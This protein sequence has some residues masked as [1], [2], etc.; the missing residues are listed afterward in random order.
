MRRFA[1]PPLPTLLLLALAAAALAQ[2]GGAAAQ[3]KAADGAKPAAGAGASAEASAAGIARQTLSWSL[4]DAIS[5]GIENNLEVAIVRYD[6]IAADYDY[7]AAL[8]AHAPVLGGAFTYEN[9]RLPVSSSFQAP[10]ERE[11]SGNLGL[12]GVLP[13]LGWFYDLQYRGRSY[14]S[15]SF[16]QDLN[17]EYTASLTGSL[18][19]P[20]LRGFLLG[21]AWTQVRLTRSARG[22]GM[23]AF[24]RQLMDTVQQI[25]SGYWNLAARLENYE[26]GRK[27]LETAR[28]LLERTEAQYEVGV[29]SRVEVVEA[30]AGVADR[31]FRMIQAENALLAA[32]DQLVHLVLGPELKAVSRYE[33]RLKDAADTWQAL[34]VDEEN[35]VQKAFNRRPELAEFR[36]QEEQA[37]LRARFARNQ[38]LPQ[39]D[40]TAGYG[41]HGLAGRAAARNPNDPLNAFRTPPQVSGRRYADTG[42]DFFGGR[43]NRRWNGGVVLSV[44]IG[45]SD[46]GAEMRKA[47]VL[48]QQ[49]RTR[50]V[51]LEQ[52]IIL[53]VRAAVRNLRSAIRGIE[54]AERRVAAASE[55]LRAEQL[56]LEYGE[57]TPFAVL[58][59]EEDMT[60]AESQRS[61]ALQV[62]H[63]SVAALSRAQGTLLEDHKISVDA[64]LPLR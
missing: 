18:N 64:A 4:R 41:T 14:R 48:L 45:P 44:P 49:T 19:A 36:Y 53:E 50:G 52:S 35:A 63:D 13:R 23:E 2:A 51:R 40:L 39:L 9:R 25:E 54:A 47:R 42:D 43:E 55:Q 11:Q 38:Y 57:S 58:Q 29:V 30:Q 17:P 7:K 21:P 6:P 26:V 22:A 10:L 28:A 8:G 16:F 33:V 56:R 15:N 60:E 12:S 27:S 34:R 32:Q 62:Y 3:D 5:L 1:A 37:E 20:L 59:R 31:E 24:R 61:A 46:R